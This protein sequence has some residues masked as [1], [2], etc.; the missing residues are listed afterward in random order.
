MPACASPAT[1]SPATTATAIGRNSGSTMASAAIANRDPLAMTADRNAGPCPG[2]GAIRVQARSTQTSVGSRL[3]SP[4]ATQVRR[5]PNSFT[6][7][8][9]ITAPPRRAV[10]PR[11]APR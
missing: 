11:S 4:I 3:S 6:S 7:S 2:R 10:G 9:R 1:A 8:T 5:R